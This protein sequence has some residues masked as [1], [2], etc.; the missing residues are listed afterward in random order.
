MNWWR[1]EKEAGAPAAG[2]G[3]K[4]AILGKEGGAGQEAEEG[5]AV[6]SMRVRGIRPKMTRKIIS[7]LMATSK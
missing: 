4:E 6:F 5:E 1:N 2:S 7:G 3:S